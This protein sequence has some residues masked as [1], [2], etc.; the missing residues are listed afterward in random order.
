M[1]TSKG[2]CEVLMMV[3][4]NHRIASLEKNLEVPQKVKPKI[5]YDPAKSRGLPFGVRKTF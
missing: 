4:L 2:V 1:K 5:T 3:G